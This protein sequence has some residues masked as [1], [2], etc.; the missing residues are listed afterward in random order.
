[1]MG[2]VDD[3]NDESQSGEGKKRVKKIRDQFDQA[4]SVLKDPSQSELFQKIGKNVL[5]RAEEVKTSI[6]ESSVIKSAMNEAKSQIKKL[7]F[8]KDKKE[9]L[10][11]A[12]EKVQAVSGQVKMAAI[13]SPLAKNLKKAYQKNAKLIVKAKSKKTSGPKKSAAK[14]TASSKVTKGTR[15]KIQK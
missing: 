13:K 11:S 6:Q 12:V 1:M 8:L 15:K 14:S 4:L 5:T 7:D 3:P 10:K 2:F 9:Q